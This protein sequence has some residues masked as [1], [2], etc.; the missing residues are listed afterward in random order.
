M[1]KRLV[2]DLI[3]SVPPTLSKSSYTFGHLTGV[4]RAF[5]GALASDRADRADATLAHRT[6]LRGGGG[7]SEQP[8][9]ALPPQT[10]SLGGT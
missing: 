1:G 8:P 4:V 10:V 7:E 6:V 3:D 2:C 5:P 9:T